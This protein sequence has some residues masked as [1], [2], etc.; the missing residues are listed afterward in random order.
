[1]VSPTVT[2]VGDGTYLVGGTDVNWTVLTDG[3]AVTLIDAGYPG[4]E[5]LVLESLRSLGFRPEQIA[6]VL[7]TH[8]HIDHVGSL[9][10]LLRRATF[11]VHTSEREAR[12]ARRE[13]LEQA[14][15]LDLVKRIWRPGHLRWSL[16]ITRAGAARHVR[17]PE[18]RPFPGGGPLDLPGRPVPI[19]TPGHTSGHTCYHL[20]E[21]GAIVTGDA[22]ITGHPTSRV[23]GPHLVAPFFSHD[24]AGTLAALDL[25][26]PVAADL[27]LPGHGPAHRGPIK[28]AVAL[29]RERAT[30]AR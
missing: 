16:A 5:R 13:Y 27:I 28:E 24:P 6:A 18:A 20:P 30:P 7:I 12:H 21:S 11:P 17:V 22:L 19:V 4:D 3:D 29:A 14:T 2:Q 23:T 26:E 10:G 8:A 25:L 15:A 9:P 1:M